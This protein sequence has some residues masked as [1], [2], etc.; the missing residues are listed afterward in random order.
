MNLLLGI[1]TSTL[2]GIA[3]GIR[4]I[5]ACLLVAVAVAICAVLVL[6]HP[7]CLMPTDSLWALSGYL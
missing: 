2:V 7:Y 4:S 1:P 3:V 5:R 6:V